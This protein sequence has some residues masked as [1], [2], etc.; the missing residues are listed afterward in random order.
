V[1]KTILSLIPNERCPAVVD[2]DAVA[3]KEMLA[4][5]VIRAS[6]GRRIVMLS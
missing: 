6:I 3:A 2:A 1:P 4:K 5:A